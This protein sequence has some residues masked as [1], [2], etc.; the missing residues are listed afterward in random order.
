MDTY[1]TRQP[2][3]YLMYKQIMSTEE[4]KLL[5]SVQTSARLE[6]IQRWVMP[7]PFKLKKKILPTIIIII[8]R[9]RR[10]KAKEM[11]VKLIW[12]IFFCDFFN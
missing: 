1:V 10:K 5:K 2:L 12:T 4:I 6:F 7:M 3:E 9:R 11:P 8:R